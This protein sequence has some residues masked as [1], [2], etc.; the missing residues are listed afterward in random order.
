MSKRIQFPFHIDLKWKVILFLLD[1]GYN[2]LSLLLKQFRQMKRPDRFV[3]IRISTR[4]YFFWEGWGCSRTFLST[5]I[6]FL[7]VFFFKRSSSFSPSFGA[8]QPRR[9]CATL[10]P[11]FF[12]D[13]HHIRWSKHAPQIQSPPVLPKYKPGGNCIWGGSHD[14]LSNILIY[15]IYIIY[16][17]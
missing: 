14:I 8:F 4:P 3:G 1:G 12:D 11:E 9:G 10:K 6:Y 7:E 17:I 2:N 5:H 15:M 16:I 13:S